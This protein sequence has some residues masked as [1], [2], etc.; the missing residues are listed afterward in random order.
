M[1]LQSRVA[2]LSCRSG[3][4]FCVCSGGMTSDA[5]VRQF[6]VDSEEKSRIVS[7]TV[8]VLRMKQS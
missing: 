1:M 6:V 4:Q 7:V 2:S 8:A 3:F 5:A